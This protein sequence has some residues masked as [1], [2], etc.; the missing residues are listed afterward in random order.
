MVPRFTEFY[1]PVL[2]VMSDVEP[3]EINALIDKVADFINLSEEDRKIPTE[4]GNQYRYR[5][6]ISWAVTDLNQGSFIERVKRGYYVITISGLELLEE[7]FEKIDRDVL[8]S[9][10][11]K[12]RAFM[13]KKGTRKGKN[14]TV[15]EISSQISNKKVFEED[16]KVD[17][18]EVSLEELYSIRK[19]LKKAKIS[20]NEIDVKIKELENNTFFNALLPRLSQFLPEALSNVKEPISFTIEYIPQR[21]VSVIFGSEKRAYKYISD[22]SRNTKQKFRQQNTPVVKDDI[23]KPNGVWIEPYKERMIVVKGDIEPF[24]DLFASYGGR[25]INNPT[26]GWKGWIF[27]R[28]REDGLRKDLDGFLIST[29]VGKVTVSESK[30]NNEQVDKS[31]DAVEEVLI[32][33][34]IN[35]FSSFKHLNFLG[36]TGPHKAIMLIAIFKGIRNGMFQDCKIKF[37]SELESLYNETWEVYVGGTPTLG[38][39]YPYVHLGR[40]SFFTHKIISPILEY[41]RT[42]NQQNLRRHIAYSVLDKKLFDGVKTQKV[43]DQLTSYLKNR[44]CETNGE[45][46]NNIERYDSHRLQDVG[47]NQTKGNLRGAFNNHLLITPANHG[48]LY[49][50]GSI[51]VY[52][53]SLISDTMK[54]IVRE[55]YPSGDIFD[56]DNLNVLGV[57]KQKIHSRSVQD[58]SLL[59]SRSAISLYIKYIQSLNK[60]N[61]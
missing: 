58:K 35:S 50:K 43:Y 42:W 7:N 46:I 37:S 17:S 18:S 44:Y 61:P 52:V 19:T 22:E 48:K 60:K 6:N 16:A 20:T 47:V 2:Q 24:S 40:E 4:S 34:Y 5:S 53:N 36:I 32:S 9:R 33:R 55:F 54:E 23:K 12:F 51:Q 38:A 10:S 45:N 14:I 11:E 13:E 26:E 41:D 3:I 25:I 57:I 30:G 59:T 56:I 27:M 21:E 8:S 15:H 1:I 39:V 31:N 29:P 49:S 28:N